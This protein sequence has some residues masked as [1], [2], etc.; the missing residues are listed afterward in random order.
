MAK[1]MKDNPKGED[2]KRGKRAP[3]GFKRRLIKLQAEWETDF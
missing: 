1:S 2:I 3:Q